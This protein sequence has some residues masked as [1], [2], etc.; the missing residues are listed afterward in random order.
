MLLAED[1]GLA[2]L[3]LG[4]QGV[5]ILLQPFFGG[6]ACVDGASKRLCHGCALPLR[7]QRTVGLTI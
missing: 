1:E 7:V 2:C 5:K 6:F 4:M 3:A